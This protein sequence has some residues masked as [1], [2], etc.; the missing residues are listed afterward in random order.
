M[1]FLSTSQGILIK[2]S[3]VFPKMLQMM[4]YNDDIVNNT[5]FSQKQI[6]FSSI[7]CH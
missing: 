5:E 3:I 7:N 1:L 2:F 6:L 4:S